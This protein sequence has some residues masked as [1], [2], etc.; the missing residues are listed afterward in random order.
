[1][2]LSRRWTRKKPTAGA[3][4][5]TIAPAAN[6]SRMNS[7]SN[8][9]VGGVVPRRRERA[10]AAVEDDRAAHEHEAVDERL[11]RAELVR[12][13]QD[14]HGEIAVQLAEEQRERLLGVDVDA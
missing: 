4:S 7:V 10:R 5:P 13:E 11:D 8:M 12:D 14:G 1:M 2:R 6:A 3:S 9:R